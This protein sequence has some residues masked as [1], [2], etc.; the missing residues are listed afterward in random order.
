MVTNGYPIGGAE[1]QLLRIAA[2]LRASGDEVLVLSLLPNPELER[3]LAADG[4]AVR[5]APGGPLLPLAAVPWA[6]VAI[7]SWR[8]AAVV[9]FVYQSVLVARLAARLA[10]RPAVV[11]SLR[12]EWLGSRGRDRLAGL[13]DGL[14]SITVV[15]SQ[16]AGA[17]LEARGALRPSRWCVIRNG[18]DLDRRE[19]LSREAIGLRPGCFAWLAAGRLVPQKDWAGLL[20]AFAPVALARDTHLLVAG[21]GVL[22]A[23]LEAQVEAAGLH[24]S[25]RFL[26]HRDDVPALLG[27]VDALVLASAWE[28]LPNVVLEAFAQGRPVVA[29]AVGGVAEL[30]Q[31]GVTGYLARPRDAAA[32]T[33]AMARLMDTPAE[34]RAAMGRQA[35]ASVTRFGW[36]GVLA[37]WSRLIDQHIAPARRGSGYG[38]RAG[39][40]RP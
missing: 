17:A 1:T 14:A 25:V 34:E 18:V 37:E 31:D 9:A 3:R 22:R 40:V 38:V 23:E 39:A 11:S 5:V 35:A 12:N 26:G 4:I 30:V 2:G 36:E 15:N 6:A 16:R 32:L 28:G 13:T 8:P 20:R 21:E 10:G 33:A 7:R 27:T 29:T 19:P 24:G